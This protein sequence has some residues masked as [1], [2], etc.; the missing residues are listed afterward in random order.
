MEI[1]AALQL[2]LVEHEVVATEAGSVDVVRVAGVAE[3]GRGIAQQFAREERQAPERGH[4]Y[5]HGLGLTSRV[6]RTAIR[7]P[8]PRRLV[9]RVTEPRRL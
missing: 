4:A 1:D 9:K 7:M 2:L 8:Y 5:C 3:R 6:R